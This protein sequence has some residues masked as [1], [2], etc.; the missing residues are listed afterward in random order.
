M[1]RSLPSVKSLGKFYIK[2]DQYFVS[3]SHVTNTK[4]TKQLLKYVSDGY[5][6]N[7]FCLG[8]FSDQHLVNV[9]V[10]HPR[11]VDVP[12]CRLF[13]FICPI[14]LLLFIFRWN[15]I[16]KIVHEAI[17]SMAGSITS[18]TN[19]LNTEVAVSSQI[20]IYEDD[21]PT[22]CLRVNELCGAVELFRDM[23]FYYYICKHGLKS[24]SLTAVKEY[25]ERSIDVNY[26]ILCQIHLASVLSAPD[27]AVML[28]QDAVSSLIVGHQKTYFRPFL[29][30][31]YCHF[32]GADNVLGGPRNITY[33]QAYDM[34]AHLFRGD[35]CGMH[36]I[37]PLLGK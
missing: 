36:Y 13:I 19:A 30:Y 17:K 28:R 8:G 4:M 20:C 31:K 21:W 14:I 33:V 15:F 6:F 5:V 18:T 37:V 22:F 16:L 24:T 23:Q 35:V 2:I 26:I 1:S 27:Y 7:E 25:I 3:W 29:L 32:S 34:A 11:E 9:L 10:S 12:N